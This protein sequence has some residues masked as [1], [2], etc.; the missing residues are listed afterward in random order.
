MG[1][2]KQAE[3]Q[4]LVLVIFVIVVKVKRNPQVVTNGNTNRKGVDFNKLF[5][6]Q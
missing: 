6:I 2:P 5:M 1:F 3:K 4:I